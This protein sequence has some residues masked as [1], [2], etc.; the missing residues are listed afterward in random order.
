MAAV[1]GSHSSEY[2][3]TVTR[4]TGQGH[5]QWYQTP[6]VTHLPSP[7]T[8]APTLLT[9]ELLP[10]TGVLSTVIASCGSSCH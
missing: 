8:K 10:S 4:H 1:L 2:A 5:H 6:R 9:P 7:Y 3:F